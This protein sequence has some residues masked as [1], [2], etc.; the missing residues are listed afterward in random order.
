MTYNL[1]LELCDVLYV[2]LGFNLKNRQNEKLLWNH[3][4]YNNIKNNIWKNLNTLN[5]KIGQYSLY[6]NETW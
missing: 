1:L 5:R 2:V 3:R 6:L 4:T